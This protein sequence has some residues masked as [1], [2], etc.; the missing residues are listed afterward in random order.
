M[1]KTHPI[2][3]RMDPDIKARLEKLAVKDKRSLSSYVGIVLEQHVREQ[4]GASS[5]TARSK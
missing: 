1:K 2:A 5:K 4:D 3:I